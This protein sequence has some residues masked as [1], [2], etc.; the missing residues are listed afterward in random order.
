MKVSYISLAL[1]AASLGCSHL[2]DEEGVKYENSTFSGQ[3]YSEPFYLQLADSTLKNIKQYFEKYSPSNS[4]DFNIEDGLSSLSIHNNG[5]LFVG[6]KDKAE[7]LL[8]QEFR[9][10]PEGQ[11]LKSNNDT[12]QNGNKHG[13]SIDNGLL[14]FKGM[15]NWLMN[16]QNPTLNINNPSLN[17][18]PTININLPGSINGGLPV[19]LSAVKPDGSVLSSFQTTG[20]SALAKRED[21]AKGNC[22]RIILNTTYAQG[23]AHYHNHLT[24]NKTVQ[25]KQN[26]MVSQISDGQI[27]ANIT[28][29]QISTSH[30]PT[31]NVST[32][33]IASQYE[34][35]ALTEA[36]PR[37][38]IIGVFAIALLFV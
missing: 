7:Y 6:L 31:G 4:S 13:F 21:Q 23:R 26:N 34:G 3:G 10:S 20:A 11:L 29:S 5:I 2:F 25:Y 14:S 8:S 28:F 30:I 32:S 35:F 17:I 33:S 16:I 37:S 27:Q 19:S 15:D 24:A 9:L 22:N 1:S 18:N 38:S 36:V 12:V